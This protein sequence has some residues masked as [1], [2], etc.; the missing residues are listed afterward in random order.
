MT[1]TTTIIDRDS[2]NAMLHALKN[3]D[4]ADGLR[5]ALDDDECEWV[6]VELDSTGRLDSES[7]PCAA[8]RIDYLRLLAGLVAGERYDA[9]ST[10][11]CLCRGDWTD[12]WPVVNARGEL[13]GDVC[14]NEDGF[15]SVDNLAIV[16]MA[17]L[18][19]AQRATLRDGCVD[20][21][22]DD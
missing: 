7:R 19:P 2:W 1:R 10:E 4:T 14:G 13:T 21:L 8:E 17:D 3:D 6:S 11:L 9:L 22:L 18:S 15:A 12:Y 20:L 16:R 5:A